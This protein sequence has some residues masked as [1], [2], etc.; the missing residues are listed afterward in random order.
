MFGQRDNA[1]GNVPKTDHYEGVIKD[2]KDVLKL[3][4]LYT[5]ECF[6]HTNTGAR[7]QYLRTAFRV[8]ER[9]ILQYT[10]LIYAID[11]LA[12]RTPNDVN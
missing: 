1:A 10:I 7:C 4:S 11:V 2:L 12:A 6:I 8:T 3:P 5:A 9:Q